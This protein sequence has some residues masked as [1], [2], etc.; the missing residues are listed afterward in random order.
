MECGVDVAEDHVGGSRDALRAA[1]EDRVAE[2]WGFRGDE[3]E[4]GVLVEERDADPGGDWAG[5]GSE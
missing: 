2:D 1:A 5:L 3:L 4:G